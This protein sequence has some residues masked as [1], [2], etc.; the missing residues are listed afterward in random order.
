MKLQSSTSSSASSEH[1][2]I[3]EKS[4][5]LANTSSMP[6]Y[7][8]STPPQTST[9]HTSAPKK[10]SSA[11]AGVDFNSEYCSPSVYTSSNAT[12]KAPRL[13]PANDHSTRKPTLEPSHERSLSTTSSAVPAD[14]ECPI[15][16]EIMRDPVICSDGFS[17]ER[18]AISD[19]LKIRNTSPK[20]NEILPN[21][22]LI[23]NKI[24]K[25]MITEWIANNG[26]M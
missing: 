8:S 5:L 20:T 19:W 22:T 16:C 24:L 21:T 13:A 7:M 11:T 26:E 15:L 4:P 3:R 9:A 6:A 23:P 14:Y 1:H 18:S 10:R 25:N 17:Y 12:Y 2:T